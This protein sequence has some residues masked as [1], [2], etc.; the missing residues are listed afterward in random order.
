MKRFLAVAVAGLGLGTGLVLLAPAGPAAAHPLGNFSVNQLES[1]AL[2]P[3]RIE[4]AAIV[5]TAELPTLQDKS[6]VDTSGD[7]AVSDDERTAH[8][9]R[10]CADLAGRFALSVRGERLMWTVGASSYSYA[11]GAAGLSTSR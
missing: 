6:T 8:A 11:S 4:A 5:D 7:G 3:D 2:Y 9:A 1:L 10:V